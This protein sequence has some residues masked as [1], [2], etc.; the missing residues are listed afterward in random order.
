MYHLDPNNQDPSE[1]DY[2]K[3]VWIKTS[4]SLEGVGATEVS[5]RFLVF[6][7]FTCIFD[8]VQSFFL[9]FTYFEAEVAASIADVLAVLNSDK[10]KYGVDLAVPF[11]EAVKFQA[12]NRIE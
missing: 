7:D 4:E 11:K 3:I 8:T 2:S 6:G 5:K 1:K 12:H 10:E 9:E